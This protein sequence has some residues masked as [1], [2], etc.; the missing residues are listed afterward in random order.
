LVA[1]L[2]FKDKR[3]ILLWVPIRLSIDNSLSF[4]SQIKS[5]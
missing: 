2:P 5:E 4:K 1:R 3:A